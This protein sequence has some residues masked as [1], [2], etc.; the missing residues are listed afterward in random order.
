MKL[1]S[2]FSGALRTFSYWVA[3]GSVGKPL[4]EGIDYFRI[5][6]EEPSAFERLYA[7]FVNVL[8]LDEN[9]IVLNA[10]H[11]ERRAAQWLRAYMD[12]DFEVT[13]PFEDWELALHA[14]PRDVGP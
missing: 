10:K 11:A 13:P 7:I 3:A 12:P 5:L 2:S 6:S 8:E 1:S 14:P 9:G 4:L